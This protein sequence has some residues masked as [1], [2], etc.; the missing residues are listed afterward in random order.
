MT[1]CD[2]E[3]RRLQLMEVDM[4]KEFIRICE[5]LHLKY[6][7]LGGTLLG[8]VRHN[9]FIPWDDDIDVGMPRADFQKFLEKAPEMLPEGLFLQTLWN[10]PEYYKNIAKIRN[11]NTT[12]IEKECRYQNI[13]HGIFIDVF[14]LDNYPTG[15]WKKKW[16][17]IRRKIL[18]ARIGKSFSWDN[19]SRWYKALVKNILCFFEP[20][21]KKAV[22]NREKMFSSFAYSGLIANF[23]GQWGEKEIVPEEWYGEGC[24][25]SFEG[26]TVKAPKAYDKWLT[27]VYGDYMK[28]PPKEKQVSH[29]DTS[30]IDLDKPYT[31]Y[32]AH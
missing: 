22:M 24:E 21:V 10:E 25:L 28:L 11:V 1:F 30:I 14:A 26:I 13:R 19:E 9:G 20:N 15:V 7:V 31:E 16:Y 6:Y 23:C 17:K 27:Q 8:S 12:F 18:D 29:H 4:L 32:L 2:K 3:L 5:N